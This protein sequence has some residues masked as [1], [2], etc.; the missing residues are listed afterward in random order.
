MKILC[1]KIS[2]TTFWIFVKIDHI[3]F[4]LIGGAGQVAQSLTKYQSQNGLDSAIHAQI[5][6][7]L[8]TS[9]LINYKKVLSG[10]FDNYIV[11][12]NN[13]NTFFSVNSS[14]DYFLHYLSKQKV[15]ILHVHLLPSFHTL[16]FFKDISIRAKKIVWTLHDFSTLTGGCHHPLDCK[17]YENRCN[18]CPLVNGIFHNMIAKNFYDRFQFF[19]TFNKTITFVA[20]SRWV[21]Q[22]VIHS[23]I[24]KRHKIEYIP[25]PIDI[26]PQDISE[27]SIAKQILG[28][29]ENKLIIGFVANNLND[30]FKS[31]SSL[32]SLINV[33]KAKKFDLSK[34]YFVFMGSGAV[35]LKNLDFKSYGYVKDPVLKT[36]IYNSMDFLLS[37][38]ENETFGLSIA[39]ASMCGVVTLVR[40][41]SGDAELISQ[42]KTGIICKSNEDFSNAIIELCNNRIRLIG[43]QKQAALSANDNLGQEK[44]NNQYLKLYNS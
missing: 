32:E 37:F 10:V 25:N 36:Q 3:T 20:P 5:T 12:K 6:K 16:P 40:G 35:R 26:R 41:S 44:I 1:G 39:E 28:L 38:A 17:E 2:L 22:K 24:I 21:Y 30:V 23:P 42:G 33:L 43:M 31:F 9:Y 19:E 7:S 14:P 8:K 34:I 15:D 18:K 27:K 29:P 11:K 4:S 13:V